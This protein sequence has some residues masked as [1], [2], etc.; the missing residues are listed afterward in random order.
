MSMLAALVRRYDRMAA[1]GEAPV[2]GYS[3]EKIAYGVT[4]A[5]DGSVIDV[6][7]LGEMVKG[8]LVPRPMIVPQPPSGR[9]SGIRPCLL[10]DK[11][12]Y[13]FGATAPG[14]ESKRA[15]KK[16]LLPGAE[17]FTTFRRHQHD[18]IGE[19]EDAGLKAFLAFLDGWNPEDYANLPLASQMLDTNVIFRLDGEDWL[20]NKP[21][22]KAIACRSAGGKGT[23]GLCLVTGVEGP[24]ALTHDP[25]IK[26][27]RGAQSSGAAIVSFNQS[28]FTSYG[29]EQGENAPVSE[30]AAFAYTTALNA[31]LV[32]RRNC[33]Q[34]GDASVVFWAEPEG[35]E[36]PYDGEA[37]IAA[38]FGGGTEKS[39][40]PEAVLGPS[41]ET[42]ER[43]LLNALAQVAKGQP[44]PGLTINPATKFYVLGLSPNA[45][46]I[47]V[48]FWL[49]TTIQ[50]LAERLMR[51]FDD[52]HLEPP[53]WREGKAPSIR[54]LIGHLAPMRI[55][56]DGR[57]KIIFDDA[58]DH[59]TG[60]F[61]RAVLSGGDYPYAVLP[62]VLQRLKGDRVVTGLRVAL[63][64]AILVRRARRRTTP[65]VSFSE[66][67]D[68]TSDPFTENTGR[69]LGRLFALYER[70]Q[71]ACFEE[72]NSSLV[73]KFYASAMATPLYVFP[74]LDANFQHH[75]SKIRKGRNLADWA[76]KKN[77][78]A[79]AGGLLK[80]VGTLSASI[81]SYPKQMA[82]EEQGQFVIG[83]YQQKFDR[84]S[85]SVSAEAETAADR[86]SEEDQ[87]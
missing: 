17:E 62:T 87:P 47:S 3:S 38:L 28:A 65:L 2:P 9:T 55:D 1:K 13:A 8:K 21:S 58:P 31:L 73:D 5:A 67:A 35:D 36:E 68:M 76:K 12:L 7:P 54:S 25:K 66:E 71:A 86:E 30:Y 53:A 37:I 18:S 70:A 63:V 32:G 49:D 6:V 42:Q 64:K 72:L 51:H 50:Q 52:L 41:A 24:I 75:L 44:V 16:G 11:T 46:R 29:K 74:S 4:L 78:K 57:L 77:P 59:L 27:V 79:L 20:H 33:V 85:E 61:V 45:A 80:A 43:D 34:I 60:E 84:D 48:R 19:T 83:Y 81:V 39:P 40:E 15:A 26:G 10:W 56:R 23:P 22:G 82:L 69:K 14:K